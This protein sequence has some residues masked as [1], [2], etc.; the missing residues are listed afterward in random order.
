M[1]ITVKSSL[2]ISIVILIIIVVFLSSVLISRILLRPS[3]QDFDT[4]VPYILG[5][6]EYIKEHGKG[7]IVFI[8]R[9]CY[10]FYNLYRLLYPSEDCVY[11]YSSRQAMINAS[12]S[13]KSYIRTVISET[14]ET[15]WIDANGTNGS[16]VRFFRD[17]LGITDVPLK[18]LID[19]HV[20]DPAGIENGTLQIFLHSMQ[21]LNRHVKRGVDL[22]YLF[23]AP[24]NSLVDVDIDFNPVFDSDD[25]A[26]SIFHEPQNIYM[27]S[28]MT[29]YIELEKL[30]HCRIHHEISMYEPT[31]SKM[32]VNCKN[33]TNL[34]AFDIDGVCEEWSF[35]EIRGVVANL[36]Q[37]GVSICIIT[38]RPSVLHIPISN[39]GLTTYAKDNR[40]SIYYNTHTKKEPF[41]IIKSQQMKH[42]HITHGIAGNERFRT[43]LIDNDDRNLKE[44]SK[45]GFG[46]I[47]FDYDHRGS[48]QNSIDQLIPPT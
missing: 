28:L 8:S 4:F 22:E 18:I 35:V 38:A 10:L 23:R 39:M 40:M 7:K 3:A 12:P 34:V 15:T 6:L 45:S 5:F 29:R 20:S 32:N 21:Q 11:V 25:V 1:T 46:A 31:L 2:Y 44:V 27:S 43:I 41:Y 24:Y 13:Y 30:V 14:E 16:H 42:A 33:V 37:Q 9:D 19:T 36:I 47:K 48:L 26:H 17:I